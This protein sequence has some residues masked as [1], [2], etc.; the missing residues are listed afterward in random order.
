[1]RTSLAAS[2]SVVLAILTSPVAA[3]SPTSRTEG[4]TRAVVSDWAPTESRVTGERTCIRPARCEPTD[5]AI[6]KVR[7]RG[8]ASLVFAGLASGLGLTGGALALR[9]DRIDPDGSRAADEGLVASLV[10]LV[11]VGLVLQTGQSTRVEGG[12]RGLRVAGWVSF[13]LFGGG[14]LA[15]L[16]AAATPLDIDIDIT[17]DDPDDDDQPTVPP[18]AVFALAAAATTSMACFGANALLASKEARA[19]RSR[20]TLAPTLSLWRESHTESI[21]PALGLRMVF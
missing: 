11:A 21:R 18:A 8:I 7:R 10:P 4:S 20:P 15:L 9:Y 5:H 3:Q 6:T 17:G 12:R 13:V 19:R 1:M 2:F 14:L 16:V